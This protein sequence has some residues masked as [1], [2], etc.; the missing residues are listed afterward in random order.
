MSEQSSSPAPPPTHTPPAQ[1]PAVYLDQS[2][3]DGSQVTALLHGD[4]P[5]VVLLIDPHHQRLGLVEV[6]PSACRPV[7]VAPRRL[8]KPAAR[9]VE[10]ASSQQPSP[11]S[12]GLQQPR[13]TP[14]T[15]AHRHAVTSPFLSYRNHLWTRLSVT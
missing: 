7:V 12:S 11:P 2:L 15:S 3:V 9:S 14:V 5:E 10:P 1:V 6:D 8:Q 4:D 13:S